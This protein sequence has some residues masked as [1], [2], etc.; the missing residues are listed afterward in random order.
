STSNPRP[1][2]D[3]RLGYLEFEFAGEEFSV[4]PVFP[5]ELEPMDLDTI[6]QHGRYEFL[7]NV[8]AAPASVASRWR[9]E[10]AQHQL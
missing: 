10:E 5:E 7:M 1:G 2:C 4:A 6:K 8:P 9:A 3:H